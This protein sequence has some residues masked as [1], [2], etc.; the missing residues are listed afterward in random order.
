MSHAFFYFNY[1]TYV[2]SCLGG[3]VANLYIVSTNGQPQPTKDGAAGRRWRRYS[4]ASLAAVWAGSEVVAA[5]GTAA[6][7]GTV[8]AES[9]G[10]APAATAAAAA[11][12][13]AADIFHTLPLGQLT[14]L[15]VLT[16]VVIMCELVA[17]NRYT[18]GYALLAFGLIPITG[19]GWEWLAGGD[20]VSLAY[21]VGQLSWGEAIGLAALVP[22]VLLF[23]L[24]RL[25]LQGGRKANSNDSGCTLP[26]DRSRQLSTSQP[27]SVREGGGGGGFRVGA[28][29]KISGGRDIIEPGCGTSSPTTRE[30]QRGCDA[31]AGGGLSVGV[32]R[33]VDRVLGRELEDEKATVEGVMGSV[34]SNLLKNPWW[35]SREL[36]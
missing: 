19:A 3:C 25:R 26:L 13:A 24:T 30:V 14:Y 34:V 4:T 27:M 33:V 9:P 15:G 21:G 28:R 31:D 18:Q 17:V 22:P 2:P 16:G 23:A 11:A 12:A 32:R 1:T 6:G 8:A 29:R 36:L 10:T 20:G 35:G 7:I 5:I